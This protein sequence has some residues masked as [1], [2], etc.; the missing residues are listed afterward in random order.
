M[1]EEVIKAIQEA[2]KNEEKETCFELK[3]YNEDIYFV[4]R[5]NKRYVYRIKLEYTDKKDL[6]YQI[7]SAITSKLISSPSVEFIKHICSGFGDTIHTDIWIE[8]TDKVMFCIFDRDC[9]FQDWI[10]EM[11]NKEE[12]NQTKKI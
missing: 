9:D 3:K 11:E 10:L 6:C 12:I 4:A 2:L 1:I 5:E 8:L 7:Y